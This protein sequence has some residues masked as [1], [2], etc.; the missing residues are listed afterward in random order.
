MKKNTVIA[1]IVLLLVSFLFLG[2][3]Q[4]DVSADML[5]SDVITGYNF[6]KFMS[7]DRETTYYTGWVPRGS[8]YYLQPPAVPDGCQ[9]WYIDGD[10]NRPFQTGFVLTENVTVIA[11]PY[12]EG[13]DI[14][15]YM[16]YKSGLL[17]VDS[18]NDQQPVALTD[19]PHSTTGR[20]Q[21]VKVSAITDPVNWSFELVTEN[22]APKCIQAAV[23]G[24]DCY[25]K[26][27]SSNDKYLYLT[28]N[29]VEFSDSPKEVF[30]GLLAHNV[31]GG[32]E[33]SF[34]LM[35]GP[36]GRRVNLKGNTASNG[37][38][39]SNGN[40]FTNVGEIFYFYPYEHT[41]EFTVTFDTNGGELPAPDPKTVRGYTDIQL[42][43]YDGTKDG[44]A[45]VGWTLDRY[46]TSINNNYTS[47]KLYRVSGDVT[48]YAVYSS[49][50]KIT[51]DPGV[52]GWVQEPIITAVKGTSINLE[53]PQYKPVYGKHEFLGWG[54]GTGANFNNP[55]KRVNQ[56][57]YIATSNT[58]L[59][60]VW[61]R[62]YY[63]YFNFNGSD[64]N[65]TSGVSVE[66]GAAVDFP[67]VTEVGTLSGHMFA[68]WS[69][70]NTGTSVD[71]DKEGKDS[72]GDPFKM[73][74]RDVTLYA[75]WLPASVTVTLQENGG[76]QPVSSIVETPGKT[77]TLPNL[78]GAREGFTFL[79][80]A[81]SPDSLVPAYLAGIEN[82]Y[83]IPANDKVL[84]AV[85]QKDEITV[86]FDKNGGTGNNKTESYNYGSE[87]KIAIPATIDS[88]G[89]TRP[90]YTFLGWSTDQNSV[91][92][93]KFGEEISVPKRDL[94]IYAVWQ[95]NE[96]TVTF[97][98][99]GGNAECNPASITQQKDSTFTA[100]SYTGSKTDSKGK[101]MV[102]IGWG[103]T[104]DAVTYKD[105]ETDKMPPVD[106]TLYAVWKTEET[107]TLTFDV[108]YNL[109][110]G[111]SIDKNLELPK[112][113][114]RQSYI[115]GADSR[116]NL[117]GK[118]GDFR[119]AGWKNE[120]TGEI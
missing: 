77:V 111:K 17:V 5:R 29:T 47:G 74:D 49:L 73:P 46:A 40:N 34:L 10:T 95:K 114:P 64:K 22:G 92:A 98:K 91:Q 4:K 81:D 107:V 97:D 87:E 27:K 113:T 106:T 60:A 96:I 78:S 75:V 32:S 68:G 41:H 12:P 9:G 61:D 43:E 67:P 2:M 89:W 18:S 25:Y 19:Q 88:F 58:T 70:Y 24:S 59:Y 13:A 63:V 118:N 90:G 14:M 44:K 54:I 83:T 23:T 66:Q 51:L 84:Y 7:D 55:D 36:G 119:F 69:Y 53:Q 31:E 99:N 50:V 94:T 85:W 112:L 15:D 71:F 115:F 3:T 56:K 103:T 38:Q 72:T 35:A 16:Y 42:P 102:F 26:V 86:T 79:G 76:S 101:R 80:W 1:S 82:P 52:G 33:N 108:Q 120:Q 104:K 93:D 65:P 8:F 6:V 20:A 100:P 105:G 48:F 39:N 117:A 62:N 28:G 21:A 57:E 116:W 45:F 110:G 30:V 11:V 37:F 109:G